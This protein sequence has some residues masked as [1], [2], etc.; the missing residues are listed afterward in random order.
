M[1]VYKEERKRIY[2][3]KCLSGLSVVQLF[4]EEEIAEF[5]PE[6]QKQEQQKYNSKMTNVV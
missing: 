3:T 5:L 6:K 1:K 4:C 2:I